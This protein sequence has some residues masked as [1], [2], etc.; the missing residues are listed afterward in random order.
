MTAQRAHALISIDDYLARELISDVKHDYIDGAV[1]AMAGGKVRHNRIASNVLIALGTQLNGKPCQP[2][3]SDMKIRIRMPEHTR[4]YYPDVSVICRSNQDDDTFQDNP[5][6]IIEVI[7][8]STRRIDQGE[9]RDAYLSIPTLGA[10]VLIEQGAAAAVV[11]QRRTSGFE[12]EVYEGCD[13]SI[14]L[15]EIEVRLSLAEIYNGVRIS[16]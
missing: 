13:A 3:N 15:P 7:S 11:Y 8:D 16:G 4:F 2:F 9:K 12:R 14:P 5:V 6:V 10:Y 1:F